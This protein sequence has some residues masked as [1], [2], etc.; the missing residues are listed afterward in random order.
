MNTLSK[1]LSQPVVIRCSVTS[2][3]GKVA[4]SSLILRSSDSE[5]FL[6]ME[7]GWSWTS[8][9][10]GTS[11]AVRF[12]VP[13]LPPIP[14]NSAWASVL[15][16]AADGNTEVWPEPPVSLR[17]PPTQPIPSY[18]V[19]IN[20]TTV[21]TALCKLNLYFSHRHQPEWNHNCPR[22]VKLDYMRCCTREYLI[23]NAGLLLRE[24]VQCPRCRQV[25][26]HDQLLHSSLPC[27]QL[28][29]KFL[30]LHK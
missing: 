13:C 7:R 1:C 6:Q 21:L 10:P 28:L 4:F 27:H 16:S 8:F 22:E 9:P 15:L 3:P 24:L 11:E 23:G 25:S 19:C 17:C 18:S 20:L 5:C 12:L 14:S 2:V 29:L 26:Q 30:S